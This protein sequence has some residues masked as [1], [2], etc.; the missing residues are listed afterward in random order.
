MSRSRR[1][2]RIR[3]TLQVARA[4]RLSWP[5]HA[6]RSRL[7]S[8]T[9]N[10][11]WV[12]KSTSRSRTSVVIP[13]FHVKHEGRDPSGQGSRVLNDETPQPR[14]AGRSF[15]RTPQAVVGG[16]EKVDLGDPW[17]VLICPRSTAS[18]SEEPPPRADCLALLFAASPEDLPAQAFQQRKS[19]LRRLR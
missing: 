5:D 17:S 8:F 9:W 15:R 14:W 11:D 1:R 10:M 16:R 6:R 7:P 13:L 18:I 12:V 2:M 19:L 4:R 3:R